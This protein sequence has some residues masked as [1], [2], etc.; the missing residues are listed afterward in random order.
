MF[1]NVFG[2]LPEVC[3]VTFIVFTTGAGT[4]QK[5]QEWQGGIRQRAGH[6][7]AVGQGVVAHDIKGVAKRYLGTAVARQQ[8]ETKHRR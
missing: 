8:A 7:D 4:M 3:K 1:L 5:Y 6:I 2:S